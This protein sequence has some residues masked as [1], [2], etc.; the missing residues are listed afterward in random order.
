MHS[1]FSQKSN[2]TFNVFNIF[3]IRMLSCL[4]C[5]ALSRVLSTGASRAPV[6]MAAAGASRAPVV[7]TPACAPN[8]MAL[9]RYNSTAQQVTVCREAV[10]MMINWISF[11]NRVCVMQDKPKKTKFGPLTDQD[12]IFT[13]LYGRH[14]WR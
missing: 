9:V 13:N 1:S 3:Q 4:G 7:S 5:P 12:R 2:I 8:S 6:A 11:Y 14:D 10:H